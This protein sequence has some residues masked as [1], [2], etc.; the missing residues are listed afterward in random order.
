M[1]HG[2]KGVK[3]ATGLERAG[4]GAL[5]AGAL[6]GGYSLVRRRDRKPATTVAAKRDEPMIDAFGVDRSDI[7]K[8]GKHVYDPDS[9]ESKA[10]TKKHK[11]HFHPKFVHHIGAHRFD[12]GAD[13]DEPET[14]K[15][16]PKE[17]FGGKFPAK[18]GHKPKK[19]VPPPSPRPRTRRSA[20]S[21][22]P[23]RRRLRPPSGFRRSIPT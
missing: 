8:A 9:P 5:G 16:E 17:D 4:A 22:L 12:H 10:A 11:G 21:P 19:K 20:S 2:V 23:L 14:K 3:L 15:D 18:K 1:G 7:A 6:A 13:Q